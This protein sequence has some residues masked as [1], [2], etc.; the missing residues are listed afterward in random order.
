[1]IVAAFYEASQIPAHEIIL[2]VAPFHGKLCRSLTAYLENHVR[3]ICASDAC[4]RII[5]LKDRIFLIVCASRINAL[6]PRPLSQS[7]DGGAP[8]ILGHFSEFRFCLSVVQKD[9][10]VAKDRNRVI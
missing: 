4:P 1:M 6:Y 9:F 3:K 7:S 8:D 2:T 10:G 5:V